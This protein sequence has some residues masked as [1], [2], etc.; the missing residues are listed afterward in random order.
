MWPGRRLA[1]YRACVDLTGTWQAAPAD[2]ELRRTFHH[3]GYDDASWQPVPVPGHWADHAA[4]DQERSMLF[5]RAFEHALPADDGGRSWLELDGVCY[6]GDVWLDGQ[7]LGDTEGYFIRHA[8]DVTELLKDRSEHELALEVNCSPA[9]TDGKRRSLLGVFEGGNDMVPHRNPGG[10]WAPVR[11]RHTGPVRIHGVRA[12][13]VEADHARAVIAVRA[14][15]VS[16]SARVVRVV[17]EI[18]GVVHEADHSIAVG[19]NEVEWRVTV[20]EPD[21]WWPHR[22]GPQSLYELTVRV[23]TRAD[24]VS[25][26][27]GQLVGLRSVRVRRW[28]FEI[29]GEA[30]FVKGVN[31]GPAGASPAATDAQAVARQIGTAKEAGLDLIRP[32][33]H[34]APDEFYAQ[35]DTAG[36]LVWQDLPLHGQASNSLRA[37]AVRQARA[38]V[39]QLGH[40]PS[41]VV[42]NAHVAPAPEQMEAQ[43][44]SARRTAARVAAHQLPTWSKSVLDRSIK[45]VF[46]SQDGSRHTCGF[47]GV[48]PHLPRLEGSATHLWFGW[49]RGTERDLPDY[50]ARWPAQVRFVAEFGAQSVPASLPVNEAEWPQALAH[51]EADPTYER[52][53]FERYVPP[54]AHQSAAAWREA[55]Q[56]YQA[57]L[58]RRQIEALRRLKYTPTGG[59]CIHHLSDPAH[60][61]PAISA[62]L[63]EA[64]GSPKPALQA[65]ADACRPV[66]VVADRLPARLVPGTPVALDIHV[67]NDLRRRLPC[68]VVD[69]EIT[70]TGGSHRWRFGGDVDPD[71]VARVGMLSWVVPDAAGLVTL[72]L[73]LSGP[74][75]AVNRYDATIR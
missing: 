37:E 66:I 30:L 20:P 27:H 11:L 2:E 18:G 5:R 26:Q 43:V 41:I 10:I 31:A 49:R 47:T 25:D 17:T 69:A 62:S 12:I 6:Q 73:R 28:R 61:A 57:G 33:A 60:A 24:E 38:M 19:E 16:G 48:L 36:M 4:F 34:V 53:S 23:E 9:G 22:L 1:A 63:V 21:L 74:E 59:F 58:L 29:N 75:E 39:D 44:P 56:L 42:W 13:C 32:Y 35:A 64:D 14:S 52:A 15:L 45:N 67:V 3:A 68:A 65:V 55:S 40:H 8:F 50:A 54:R 70:W 7:Y 51:I 71:A 72:T 46:D